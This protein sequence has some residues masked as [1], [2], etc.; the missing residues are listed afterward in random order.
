MEP[1]TRL[2]TPSFARNP[3]IGVMVETRG[4]DTFSKTP[5]LWSLFTFSYFTPL[6]SKVFRDGLKNEDIPPLPQSD[7]LDGLIATFDNFANQYAHPLTHQDLARVL[8]S[9]NRGKFLWT[10]TLALY[11]A[12]AGIFTPLALRGVIVSITEPTDSNAGLWYAFGLYFCLVSGACANVHCQHVL[13]NVGNRQRALL[14]SIIFRKALEQSSATYA[15]DNVSFGS[16]VNLLSNDTQKLFDVMPTIHLT[17]TA[18]LQICLA[19]YLLVLYLG[20][21]AIAGIVFLA[22]MSP[23]NWYLS[24][25]IARMRKKHM[26]LSDERVN[27]CS[28][29]FNGISVVKCFSW[30]TKFYEKILS[31]RSKE[32][33]YIRQETLA[34]ANFIVLLIVFPSCSLVV[35]FLTYVYI[36]SEPLTAANA[37]SAI[38]LFNALRF[39]LMELGQI[40]NTIIQTDTALTRIARFLN[41]GWGHR[42]LPQS[43]HAKEEGKAETEWRD[44]KL[45]INESVTFLWQSDGTSPNAVATEE[46]APVKLKVPPLVLEKGTLMGVIGKVG[47]GKTLFIQSML[48][49]TYQQSGVFTITPKRKAYVPQRAWVLNESLRDN[50]VF[51]H[52]FDEMVYRRVIEA[53]QLLPDIRSM[54]DGDQTIIGERGVTLSGGQKQRTSLARATYACLV[55]NCEMVL[56]DDPLSAL[57]AHTGKSI[58]ERVIGP[59]G[60]LSSTCRI[61]VT[62]QNHLLPQCTCVYKISDGV[63][64][65]LEQ[66]NDTVISEDDN[67]WKTA[68]V[69]KLALNEAQG[70]DLMT[71]E[72]DALSGSLDIKVVIDYFSLGNNKLPLVLLGF[73]FLLERGSYGTVDWWLSTWTNAAFSRPSNDPGLNLPSAKDSHVV[74]KWYGH[75]YI[76]I[77]GI[78]MVFVFLRLNVYALIAVKNANLLFQKLLK[79]VLR[80]DLNFFETTPHGRIQ[81]RFSFDTETVDSELFR[82]I[83]GATASTM[84]ILTGVVIMIG[85]SPFILVGMFPIFYAYKILHKYYRVI[86]VEVQRMNNETRSP[87]QAKFF[88]ALNG[89][90]SIR[91]YQVRDK[92][93]AQLIS[94]I[95][96]SVA[97]VQLQIIS[98]RW[99]GIRLEFLAA[100]MALFSSLICWYSRAFLPPALAGLM[101]SWSIQFSISLNFN[102]VNTTEAEA[103][104]S[105]VERMLEYANLPPESD[106]PWDNGN[107][108][109]T[110]ALHGKLTFDHVYFK[111]RDT[112]EPVLKGVSFEIPAGK[113]VGICGRTGSGKSTLSNALFRFREVSD[114]A[115]FIDDIK[116]TNFPLSS[117]RGNICSCIPQD[118][119]LFAGSL[120]FNLDPFDE[121]N[122]ADIW[123]S[124]RAVCLDNLVHTLA[125]QQGKADTPLTLEIKDAGENLSV[126]QR[127]LICFARTIL[128]K[129]TILLLDEATSSCDGETDHVIQDALRSEFD[130]TMLIIAHRLET[131]MDVDYILVLDDGQCVEFA[132][133]KELLENEASFFSRLVKASSM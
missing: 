94:A 115:I 23:T 5:P 25:A 85:V 130:C 97:V 8:F 17:W 131:I 129:P 107:S 30:E 106:E 86:C 62:H 53:C 6:V 35:S 124:L 55:G 14:G 40:L 87:I 15:E 60:L 48:G 112:L 43:D 103:K 13:Y 31:L 120:R 20:E 42:T 52:P 70:Q 118:P 84:W 28:E 96:D 128:A 37:F 109:K 12:A 92:F 49:E 39:P 27:L 101:V 116:L 18:P 47:C 95:E 114:G 61:L 63:L 126:G 50:I 38:A 65:Q 29:I 98:T 122:D 51:H 73:L 34:F 125:K 2:R 26:P 9:M 69:E 108:N 46:T 33:K 66:V 78:M 21:A 7:R 24:K 83:N 99:L 75:V 58:F 56:L 113:K 89:L 110:F 104:L 132:S 74:S 121:H 72:R 91:A 54:A 76:I 81:N 88:E 44:P 119:V 71:S 22:L 77:T 100:H 133:P 117:L 68:S 59:D 90:Q 127:Q 93:M 32:M 111:Y 3:V 64:I 1:A 41:L 79:G 57:D 16:V 80:A 105:S 102:I 123:K 11:A 4:G 45:L 10:A 82:R 36:S 67:E 19:T